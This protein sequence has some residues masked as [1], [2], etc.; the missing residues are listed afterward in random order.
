MAKLVT[1]RHTSVIKEARK[2]IKRRT[3]NRIL[4]RKLKK[5]IK[6]FKAAILKKDKD[7]EKF[8]KTVHSVLDKLAKKKIYHSNKV[9][10]MKSRL[11]S[12]AKSA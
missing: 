7:A 10:R 12:F 3:S 1:G 11:A 5:E 8:L 9:S 2:S 4:V 6:S